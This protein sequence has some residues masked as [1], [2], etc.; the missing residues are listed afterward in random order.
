MPIGYRQ[1]RRQRMRLR[2]LQR[3][4]CALQ[5]LQLLQRVAAAAFS[6]QRLH[7]SETG[8]HDVR[9]RVHLA[10]QHQQPFAI[11][12]RPVPGID[13][14]HRT[15]G[16]MPLLTATRILQPRLLDHKPVALELGHQTGPVIDVE[17][18][19]IGIFAGFVRPVVG[20]AGVD[21]TLRGKHTVQLGQQAVRLRQMLQRFH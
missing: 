20:Y 21:A 18:E 11:A 2:P 3:I 12:S 19:R 4:C 6:N 17:V 10:R 5:G 16:Q 1:H 15:R 8:C 7:L 14:Q 9:G 13:L